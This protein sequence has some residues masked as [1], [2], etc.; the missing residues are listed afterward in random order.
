MLCYNVYGELQGNVD[1]ILDK[2][3]MWIAI[4]VALGIS[5]VVNLYSDELNGLSNS[6]EAGLLEMAGEYGDYDSALGID[7]PVHDPSIFETN[8]EFYVV[9]TDWRN[10]WP[11]F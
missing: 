1:F 4:V 10:D 11:T 8:N 9:S 2:L 5:I 7:D 3:N 6:E